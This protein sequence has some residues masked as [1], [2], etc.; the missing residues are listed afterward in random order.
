VRPVS[1][2]PEAPSFAAVERAFAAHIRDPDASPPPP[3]VEDRRLAVYRELLLNNV[4][5]F[6]SGAFPVLRRTLG[7]EAWRALVRH[8]FSRHRA[9]TPLFPQMP[10]ELLRYLEE[11]RDGRP[12]DP[13]WVLELAHYEWVEAALANDP[14]EIDLAEV[15]PEGDLLTGVPVPSPLAWLL[16]YRFPVHRIAPDF[17][18]IAP[19]AQPTHLVVYRDRQDAVGFLELNPVTARLVQ[20]IASG[21]GLAGAA[22]LDRIAGEIAHPDPAQVRR[23]GGEILEDLRR[24][25]V[26]LGVRR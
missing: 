1:Q 15:D 4:E 3:G 7:D 8:F 16:T 12:Q 14:R 23:A 5:G 21:E 19:P 24:R 18:P 20:L 17:Q 9:E 10:R 6:L 25:D 11:S 26:I 13:A 22:A 2:S